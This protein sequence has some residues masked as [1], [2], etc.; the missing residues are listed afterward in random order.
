MLSPFQ[1]KI[2]NL[3]NIFQQHDQQQTDR[4]DRYRNIEPES[5]LFL[6]IL[7]RTH[8]A[9]R[10][11]EIG[12]STGYSTLWLAEALQATHGSMLSLEI[13]EVRTELA[14]AYAKQ[15]NLDAHIDFLVT[16]AL[17]YLQQS[18]EQFDLILLDAERSAY[19]E[20]WQYLP[21][22]L[23]PKGGLLVVDNVVSHADDVSAFIQQIENN[24]Q[25]R[26]TILTM[27]AG[28][29]LVTAL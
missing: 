20:Y 12:T 8:Q 24:P 9:K 22:L 19:L 15:F 7:V 25:F 29:F 11:L 18:E 23:N 28:L 17:A 6:N 2:Q 16:D 27:G 10:I 5:A 26:T 13:D 1:E 14:K 4:L 21:K 3:Y